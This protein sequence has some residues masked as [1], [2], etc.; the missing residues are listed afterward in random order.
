MTDDPQETFL[1]VNELSARYGGKVK[2]RTLNNLRF[3]GGGPPFVKI[4]GRVLYKLSQVV[5]WEEQRNVR[6]TSEYTHDL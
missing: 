3:V 2:V 1:T 4:G 6:T 5:E